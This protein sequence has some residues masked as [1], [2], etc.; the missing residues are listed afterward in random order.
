MLTITTSGSEVNDV[1]AKGI[2]IGYKE[3]ATKAGGWGGGGNYVYAGNMIVSGGCITV[4]SSKSEGFEVK[5]DLT[6]NGG[7]TYVFSGGDD[8][9]NSQGELTV[10]DGFVFGY[11]TGNDGIDANGNI[12]LN[13]GY[14][15]G[16]CTRG[17]PEVG[18]DANS[19]GGYKLYI[20]S[21]A[22]VVAYGGLESGYSAAQSVYTLSGTAGAWNAL[23][24]GSK[25]I[26]A[27]KAPAGISSFAVSAP[28]LS[29]GYK[30][31]TVASELC[32]GVWAVEGI[33]GGSEVTLT[34]YSGGGGF[35]P[36][37]GGGGGPRPP[38]W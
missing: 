27:F 6:F 22:T 4:N 16:I 28:G 26:A 21:G 15:F 29:S 20:N 9:I 12:K 5:G 33:S 23:W 1:S 37:G 36:G 2:K 18:L 38:G 30:G 25:F 7:E 35:G 31:V 11:S 13:G 8:A 19:E 3:S 34:T 14:T 32:G 10:N 17:A 24:D